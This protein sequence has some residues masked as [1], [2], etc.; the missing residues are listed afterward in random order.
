[1][2]HSVT[3]HASQC[4]TVNTADTNHDSLKF[5]HSCKLSVRSKYFKSINIEDS[6]TVCSSSHHMSLSSLTSY[7]KCY[8]FRHMSWPTNPLI[9]LYQYLIGNQLIVRYLI[10]CITQHNTEPSKTHTEYVC[11]HTPWARLNLWPQQAFDTW[12]IADNETAISLPLTVIWAYILFRIEV[13]NCRKNLSGVT[14]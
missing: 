2:K 10:L 12:R 14:G 8:L 9:V 1:M 4:F 3:L 7:F 13:E 6:A 5:T 11:F